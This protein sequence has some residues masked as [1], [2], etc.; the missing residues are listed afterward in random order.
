MSLVTS[1]DNNVGSLRSVQLAPAYAFSSL[2][3]LTFNAGY[4]WENVDFVDETAQL[5]SA[6]TE[7]DSG[8]QHVYTLNFTIYKNNAALQASLNN[9]KG[10]IAIAKVTD[11][12]GMAQ[13][14]GNLQSPL[15]RAKNADTGKKY[16][17][18]NM[19]QVTFAVT[20][21]V[22]ALIQ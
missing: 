7:V 1:Q 17:D 15:T 3:P 13:V 18:P 19:V 16:T 11:T 8:E 14:V 4:A 2:N 12:N 6:S 9:Y 22:E 5:I 20:Q 21:D 10:T